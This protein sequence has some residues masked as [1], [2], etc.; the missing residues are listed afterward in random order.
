MTERISLAGKVAVVTG[1][2][3]GLGRAYVELLA[4]RG[5]RVVVNDAVSMGHLAL[6]RAFRFAAA[7]DLVARNV[8]ELSETPAGQH[9]RPSR[10]F[11]LEQSLALIRAS[12]GSRIGAYIALSLG[13]GIRTEEARALRW[14][15]VDFGDEDATPPRPPNVAVWRA[16]RRG[17]DAKT[18][19]SLRTL[20][21]PAFAAAALRELRDRERRDVG[22][23][24]ATRD[25]RQLDA[26]NVRREFRAAVKAAGVPGTWT[27]RELRDTFVSL[28]SET[29]VPV[30]EIARLAGHTNSRTTELV[31]RHQLKPIMENGAEVLDHLFTSTA[32]QS[33]MLMS[34]SVDP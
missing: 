24:F 10:S 12:A 16:V 33:P 15:A 30:E 21:V 17:G 11:T 13:T 23:V 2:G 5:A 8:A 31:Y 18:L 9:G 1:A 25:G 27:P 4:E 29:G 7:R 6:K 32:S 34:G 14:D 20:R 22:P 28:M 26:A 3:R 19:R